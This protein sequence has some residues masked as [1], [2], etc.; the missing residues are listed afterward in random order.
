[1]NTRD[2][3]KVIHLKFVALG[4]P[5]TLDQLAKRSKELLGEEVGL[6]TLK[7]WSSRDGWSLAKLGSFSTESEQTA[8]LLQEFYLD[9]MSASSYM[10]MA[11]YA[12]AFLSLIK[13]VDIRDPVFAEYQDRVQIVRDHL[14]VCMQK[15]SES[16]RAASKAS[17]LN[18]WVGLA[19]YVVDD[20]VDSADVVADADD[21]LVGNRDGSK[22]TNPGT[23]G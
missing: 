18:S 21:L 17:I 16:M 12:R 3:A 15:D 1:M 6:D 13:K 14:Y 10:N 19:K 22:E 9:I 11:A 4:R 2:L 20:I 23:T 5:I 7:T 8:I